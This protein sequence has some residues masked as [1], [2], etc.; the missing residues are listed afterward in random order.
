MRAERTE[1]GF[2][3]SSFDTEIQPVISKLKPV[4]IDAFYRYMSDLGLGYGEEFRS[5]RELCAGRR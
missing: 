5:V 3:D 4:D 1:S 2:A